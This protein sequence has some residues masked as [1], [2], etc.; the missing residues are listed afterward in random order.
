MIDGPNAQWLRAEERKREGQWEWEELQNEWA[1]ED[2]LA[3]QPVD[4]SSPFSQRGDTFASVVVFPF[5]QRLAQIRDES[6]GRYPRPFVRL[7]RTCD[8]QIPH[9][10]AGDKV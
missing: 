7:P 8:P 10:E 5:P 2:R 4:P 6:P 1:E 3:E 9:L